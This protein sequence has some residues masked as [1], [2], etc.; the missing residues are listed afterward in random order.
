MPINI[1][2]VIMTQP[3]QTVNLNPGDSFTMGGQITTEKGGAWAESGDMYFEWDQGIGSWTTIVGSGDLSTQNTNPIL[4][5][6]DKNE[7][8]ITVD[9][10]IGADGSFNVRV[11]LIE[12]D[13]T[14]HTTT[15][16]QVN[17]SAPPDYR[18]KVISTIFV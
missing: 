17:V 3:T 10:D 16:I 5:L 11:K 4:G 14:E 12:D 8:T 18:Q 13:L 2:G 6:Q 7:H 15:S 9:S 1:T